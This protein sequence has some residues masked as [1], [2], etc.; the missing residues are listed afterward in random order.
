MQ[1]PIIFQFRKYFFLVPHA[2]IKANTE[3]NV[4][5]TG[6]TVRSNLN[7]SQSDVESCRLSCRSLG[8]KHFS[9][10]PTS[11]LPCECKVAIDKRIQGP[12]AAGVIS[13]NTSACVGEC[14]LE[15]GANTKIY[16]NKVCQQVHGIVEREN[17][18][19]FVD[20]L[21]VSHQLEYVMV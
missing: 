2:C 20:T 5:Y 1:L 16:L 6:K 17:L 4:A 3:Y 13:G 21:H 19:A 18:N 8:M 9:F 11:T 15:D 10:W 12:G 14:D 7:K